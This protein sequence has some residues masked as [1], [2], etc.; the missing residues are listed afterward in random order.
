MFYLMTQTKPPRG[1]QVTL[2]LQ[3][4][5]L[6]PMSHLPSSLLAGSVKTMALRPVLSRNLRSRMSVCS[7]S[8]PLMPATYQVLP[9]RRART[10]L[11]PG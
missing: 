6:V 1:W 3:G 10:A 4:R 11:L 7:L 2:A 8:V 9:L 5:R